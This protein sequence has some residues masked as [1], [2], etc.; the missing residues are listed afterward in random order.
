MNMI[1]FI[2]TKDSFCID[3]AVQMEYN[4]KT[5]EEFSKEAYQTFYRLAF[6]ARPDY[7]DA[8]GIYLYNL[9]ETFTEEL[10]SISGIELSR[11]N[12]E[13]LPGEETIEK[14]LGSVPFVTGAEYVTKTWIKRQYKRFLN[15]FKKEIA[16]YPGKVSL[17]FAEKNSKLRIPERV[18]FHLVENTQ[19]EFPFAFLATYATKTETGAVRHVPLQ[20]ALTEYN[21]EKEKILE[22]LSCLNRA[23]EV[24]ELIGELMESGEL[25]HP[26]GLTAEEAYRLLQDIPLLEEAGIRCRIPNWWKKRY[27]S[28][29][30]SVKVGEEKPDLLGLDSL[31]NVVP[32]LTVGGTALTEDEIKQL[33]EQTEGLSFI[34][35]RWIEVNHAQL[36]AL[37]TEL[38]KQSGE[39]T[40]LEAIRSEISHT[41]GDKWDNGVIVTNGKWLKG[42]LK[43]LRN[44]DKIK[45]TALPE[46][47]CGKLR[48]YQNSGRNWLIQMNKYGFGACLADDMGLGKTVQ[49]LAFL[50]SLRTEKP[51]L[52]V[53][54]IV[55]A[56]L[57]GNWRKETARFAPDMSV[58]ILYG[59]R[60]DMLSEHF[61]D[62][63]SF[64]TVTTYR[65]AC[66]INGLYE[67]IWDCVIL[68][69][70]QA[71]KNPS[72]NQTKHIK[73]LKSRMKIALT[74]TP[75]ENELFN[76]WS[77]FDFLNKGLLGSSDE[78]RK[79]S[80]SLSDHPEGYAKLKN[81]IAPFILRRVKTDKRVISDLPEKLE[82]KDY[83]ELSKKQ[84]VLYRKLIA[85]TEDALLNSSG[86]QRKGL[87]LSLLLHLKQIC[88]HPDQ[89]LGQE[90]FD[91]TQSGK[92][93]MLREI[94]QTIYEKRERVLVFTQF[95]EIVVFLDK[96]LSRIFHCKGGVIH[97][98]ISVK[99]RME[100][101]DRFQG[102]EY[103]PYMVLSVRAGGTGLNLTKANHVI[104]FDRWWNPSVENQATDR[105]FRIGQDK[106][107][108]VHKFIC[109]GTVEE[110]IDMLISSKEELAE[111]VIGSVGENWITEMSN[112]ELLSMLR[113]E[114]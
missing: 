43:T 1:S 84:I 57:L 93:E 4:E 69:E 23:A 108:M 38:K 76:L 29:A 109:Q 110:K 36:K 86:I 94:C 56:S 53:L 49:I 90:E 96:F 3:N 44:P 42:F 82:Q 12:T 63:D 40:F 104:H 7:L 77:I 10:S 13:L 73:K 46:S 2:F 24:S 39:M 105:A 81:M 25:F 97:G 35:G 72:T 113:L 18:F 62:S 6:S 66:S 19:G 58:E 65:M 70:A 27:G 74:G 33:L 64:L 98:G 68:D 92:F 37:L 51:N 83:I 47:F 80:R 48:P 21:G 31:L 60:S 32:S 78:F 54:L 52:K 15:I 101:V 9:A 106:N 99:E 11:E 55:P 34:K 30:V 59:K 112:D 41:S 79:F 91:P 89:Y 114:I 61:R 28:V 102:E 75:I 100:I 17:Y 16:V 88:N 107:V 8:A 5:A 45:N 95:R 67:R 103:V 111:N 26:L 20:Y 71:I 14:L 85:Q 50:E 87:V 22:L